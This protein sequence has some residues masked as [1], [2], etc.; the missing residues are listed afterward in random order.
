M[1][2]LRRARERQARIEAATTRTLKAQASLDRAVEARNLAIER[3]DERVADAEAARAAEITE[4][5]RTCRSSEAAAE[6]LGWSVQELR[7]VV[8]VDRDRRDAAT[9][10]CDGDS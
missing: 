2:A 10:A 6:I 7:R 1:A 9:G 5:V 8:K 3:Y 4:L